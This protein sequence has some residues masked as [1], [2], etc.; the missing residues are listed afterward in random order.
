M[1]FPKNISEAISFLLKAKR[2]TEI[3]SDLLDTNI[4][5]LKKYENIGEKTITVQT[6]EKGSTDAGVPI[7]NDN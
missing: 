6:T 5:C 2:A 3:T 4:Q 1:Q 7:S